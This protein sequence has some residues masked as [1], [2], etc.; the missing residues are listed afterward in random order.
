MV[1]EP[2][3]AV[4]RLRHIEVFHAIYSTGSITHAA[5]L[6][7]VSQPSISKVL[8]HAEMQL[9][10]ELFHRVKGKLVPT[11]EA[12]ALIL[13]VN[14]V[15]AQI[16]SLKKTARNLRANTSGKIRLS[17]MPAL[18]LN[19]LPL[20]IK[21]FHEQ[22]PDIQFNVQTKHFEDVPA[23]LFE[24]E[25]DIGLAFNPESHSGLDSVDI[26]SGEL[27]CVHSPDVFGNKKKI[28]PQ[29]LAGQEF[30]S[31]V[32]SGPLGDMVEKELQLLDEPP[33]TRVQVQTYYIAKSLVGYG[34]GV[35]VIDEFTAHA[36]GPGQFLSTGFEPPMT[37]S[38]KGFYLE[39]RP[40]SK[41]C[42]AFLQCFKEV[43]SE[44]SEAKPAREPVEHDRPQ[45]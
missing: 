32:D 28:Q 27:M 20:A 19:I 16:S 29:D 24:Y 9:G 39:S 12:E 41:V 14:R 26:G 2:G 10:F 40:L 15:Y 7:H 5:E 31:I 23:A 1:T 43:F 42:Q 21:R 45:R 33:D 25:I 44:L 8:K 37:F 35:S 4:L 36:E 13:E 30:I 3:D 22:Y 18:G 17:V 11:A 38:V 6:L 34:L